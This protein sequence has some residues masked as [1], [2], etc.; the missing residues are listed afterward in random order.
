[1]ALDLTA[2]KF[3]FTSRPVVIDPYDAL[4]QQAV[5]ELGTALKDV[6]VIKLEPT[7]PGDRLAWVTNED[8]LKGRPGKQRVIHLCLR[9]IKDRFKKQHGQAYTVTDPA[10][11]KRMKET[12]KQFLKDVV[13]PHETEHVHQEMEHG[14]QFGPAAEQQAEKKEEWKALEQMGI[15]K[16]AQRIVD[17]YLQEDINKEADD[18]AM[19]RNFSRNLGQAVRRGFLSVDE[20][21][22]KV[23]DFSDKYQISPI[24]MNFLR[25]SI[26]S[27]VGQPVSI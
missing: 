1:M 15:K 17:A 2:G 11:Q 4:V 9:K 18:T 16:K 10:E 20:V 24:K 14:G 21:S 23:R 5:Q 22:R 13:I 27:A 3:Q 7:C 6:D 19:I 26:Q 8:L 25:E 12:V